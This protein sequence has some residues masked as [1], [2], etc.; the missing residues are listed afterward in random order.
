MGAGKSTVG[1]SVAH[2]LGRPFVDVDEAVAGEH[3]SIAELFATQGEPA[4]REIEA[5]F[6]REARAAAAEREPSA[7]DCRE[8][9]ADGR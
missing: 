6:V 8:R 1:E 7:P 9:A 4:F 3:G 2:R 5:R